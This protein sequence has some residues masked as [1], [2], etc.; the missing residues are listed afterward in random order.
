MDGRVRRLG[1][2]LECEGA[3]SSS[4]QYLLCIHLPPIPGLV[5]RAWEL[6]IS[7][8]LLPVLNDVSVVDAGDI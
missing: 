1:G 7:H 3:E 2:P 5:N 6:E 4:S 8:A